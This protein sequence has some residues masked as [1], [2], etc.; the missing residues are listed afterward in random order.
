[1]FDWPDAA[2]WDG[3]SLPTEVDV[4]I[5][6]FAHRLSLY[7]SDEDYY[8]SL[9]DGPKFASESFVPSGLFSQW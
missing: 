7:E 5:A 1:V 2:C 3:L 9:T 4:Q 8:A 6:A